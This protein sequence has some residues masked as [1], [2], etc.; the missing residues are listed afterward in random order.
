MWG[1]IIN[2]VRQLVNSM[3]TTQECSKLQNQQNTPEL[4]FFGT[5]Y[6]AKKKDYARSVIRGLSN[7]FHNELSKA[8]SILAL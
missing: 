1:I 5:G 7:I 8:Y 6:I 3:S 2:I 4:V